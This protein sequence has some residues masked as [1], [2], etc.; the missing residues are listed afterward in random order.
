MSCSDDDDNKVLPVFPGEIEAPQFPVIEQGVLTKVLD[1]SFS[2]R[3]MPDA[4]Y[5]KSL[6]LG[7]TTQSP[8]YY[9][10]EE[11]MEELEYEPQC[12]YKAKLCTDFYAMAYRERDSYSGDKR[13]AWTSFLNLWEQKC[14]EGAIYPGETA[15]RPVM[16]CATDYDFESKSATLVDKK[17][18]L[19]GLS[20]KEIVFETDGEES[21]KF[22]YTYSL[23]AMTS[24][25]VFMTV[26]EGIEYMFEKLRSVYGNIV[27]DRGDKTW[28]LDELKQEMGLK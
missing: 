27:P 16:F 12:I 25:P 11:K 3:L 28:N 7:S 15:Y 17:F 9:W 19:F 4:K 21:T 23:T 10:M 2:A 26:T 20:D 24:A 18:Q 1:G 13:G 8:S 22:Y 5:R 6:R 14:H